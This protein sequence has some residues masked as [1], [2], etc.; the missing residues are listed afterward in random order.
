MAEPQALLQVDLCGKL[1]DVCCNGQYDFQLQEANLRPQDKT[2]AAKK[3]LF[4]HFNFSY[5]PGFFLAAAPL[6]KQCRWL[7]FDNR[8]CAAQ[9]L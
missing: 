3:P 5:F 9:A 2:F 6:E 4:L 7:L 8:K 1:S